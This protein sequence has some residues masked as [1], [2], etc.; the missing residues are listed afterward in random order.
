MK[1]SYLVSSLGAAE[2]RILLYWGSATLAGLV[3][4]RDWLQSWNVPATLAHPWL[5]ALLAETWLVSQGIYCLVTTHEGRPLRWKSTIIFA[6]GN[7]FC[8]TLAFV[9]VYRLGEV[10]GGALVGPLLPAWASNAGFLLGTLLLLLYNW[11]IHVLFWASL[12]PPHFYD[13]P[14]ARRLRR[15]HLQALGAMVMSWCLCL[16]ITRDLWTVVLLHVLVDLVLM[17]RVRPRLFA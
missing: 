6:V 1:S 8:E 13:T 14:Y 7:G 4:L 9:L 11:P 17:V 15:Y 12:L 3:F 2:R 5:V 16:W 10:I